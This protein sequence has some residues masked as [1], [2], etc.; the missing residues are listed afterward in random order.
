MLSSNKSSSFLAQ[1]LVLKALMIKITQFRSSG[2]GSGDKPG[3]HLVCY[4][5]SVTSSNFIHLLGFFT[6][7]R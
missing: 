1:E 6:L 2:P 5:G 4:L 3:P 7:E